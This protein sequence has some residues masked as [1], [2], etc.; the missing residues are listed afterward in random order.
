MNSRLW[1][2]PVRKSLGSW[3]GVIFTAPARDTDRNGRREGGY[4]PGNDKRLGSWAGVIF[5]APS[6]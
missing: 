1:R 6:E 4:S 5:T 3:A 2:L